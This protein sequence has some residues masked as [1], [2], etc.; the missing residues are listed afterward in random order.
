MTNP[1][2]VL[3]LRAGDSSP[4]MR[5]QLRA[6]WASRELVWMLVRRDL[7]VRY[8]NSRIGFF[9]SLAPLLLQVVVLTA[10]TKYV[11]GGGVA[12]L[13]AYILCASIV[14]N[15][16]KISLLDGA[17]SVLA[18]YGL[19]KKVYFPREILPLASTIANSIHALLALAVFFVYRYVFTPLV[20]GSPGPP[21]WRTLWL[22]PIL[23]LLLFLLTVGCVFFLSALTVFFE[24][25]KFIAQTL[26]DLAFFGLPIVWFTEYVIYSA[27]IP[28]FLRRPIRI[29]LDI[30][31]V[32]WLI[33]AFKQVL[34][35]RAEF[36]DA[37][38]HVIGTTGLFDFRYFALACVTTSLICLAGYA[39]FNRRK[40]LFVERP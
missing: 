11:L 22:V 29:A 33:S 13:S 6:L 27:A 21:P 39:Y 38:G 37:A 35:P 5:G 4:R 15:F 17:S 1:D 25:A 18:Q 40:W 24:D 32:S 7:R 8:K 12:G 20:F 34:L 26:L 2:A 36:R 19:L 23:C 9:W 28:E 30:N 31:P 3:Q 14:W 16:F 10:V